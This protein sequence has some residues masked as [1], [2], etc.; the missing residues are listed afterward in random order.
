MLLL[1]P[2]AVQLC[3]LLLYAESVIHAQVI[4]CSMTGFLAAAVA[5]IQV[6]GGS[7]GALGGLLMTWALSLPVALFLHAVLPMPNPQGPHPYGLHPNWDKE[8]AQA[9]RQAHMQQ[10]AHNSFASVL[11]CCYKGRSEFGDFHDRHIISCCS[12]VPQLCLPYSPDRSICLFM[13]R[14][15]C[16]R[17]C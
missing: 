13:S 17:H 4:L 6:K 15:Q 5:M 1:L 9:G 16:S 2:D 7:S 14:L 11:A 3:L 12:E 8:R 10:H